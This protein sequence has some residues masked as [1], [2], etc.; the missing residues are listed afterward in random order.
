L[1][2]V[3]AVQGTVAREV[4][5]RV[6]AK[7]TAPERARLTTSRQVDSEAYD[8]YLVGRALMSRTLTAASWVKAKEYFDT[9]A[10]KDPDYAAA[11]AGLAALQLHYR[12]SMTRNPSDARVVA[13]QLAEKALQLDDTLAEAHTTLARIAQEHEWDWARAEREYR[14]AIELNPSNAEARIRYAM[15]LYGKLRFEE[16]VVEARRAQQLDPVSPF[17]HTWAGAAYMYAGRFAEGTAACRKA[18]ALDPNYSDPSLVLARTHV[19]QG[20]YAQAIAE[21]QR[22]SVVARREP[23]ILGALA[24]AYARAGQREEA[25]KLV[26]TMKRIEAEERGYVAPFGLIWAYAVLD[27]D[28][29]FAYLEAW[30]PRKPPRM[31]WINVDP[32]L[33]PLRSDPRFK[34]LVR[35]I[36]LPM[37][38]AP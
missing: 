35:R 11:Y 26:S 5:A 14:R 10:A 23:L 29:A 17:V 21:L 31:V 6:R 38:N 9:A 28:E 2:D 8:A 20:N 30:Y 22:A 3:L 15:Y 19:A 4:A 27:K 33:E 1:R 25:L 18:L 36:G 7:V 24:H 12:G 16:A 13:R 34:E 37:R 32:L